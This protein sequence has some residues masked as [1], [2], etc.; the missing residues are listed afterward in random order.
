MTTPICEDG[1]PEPGTAANDTDKS[2]L[3]GEDRYG[4]T[5]KWRADHERRAARAAVDQLYYDMM[6]IGVRL[7]ANMIR[8]GLSA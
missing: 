3:H 2:M 1:R 6:P 8:D 4:A 7:R 5:D